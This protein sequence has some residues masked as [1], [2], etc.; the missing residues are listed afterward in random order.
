MLPQYEAHT[1][2]P[3]P[4][5]SIYDVW[6]KLETI[7]QALKRRAKLVGQL[8]DGDDA[9]KK[10]ASKL[11]ACERYP[12]C[13][14]PICPMCVRA[15]RCWFICQAIG[16]INGLQLSNPS[17]LRGKVVRFSAVPPEAYRFGHLA[18]ADL[19]ALN[20][21]LQKRHE[22]AEFPLVFAG[23][24]ISLNVFDNSTS[25]AC[26]QPHVYGLIIGLTPDQVRV[27]L[28]GH[29]PP[30]K[31][32]RR[33]LLVTRCKKLAA[34]LSY[35]IKPYFSRRSGY[36][37]DHNGRR[38]NRAQPLNGSQ[39]QELAAWLDHYRLED[40][41]LL[42]GCRKQGSSIAVNPAVRAELLGLQ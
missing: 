26:W 22:R 21:K 6:P 16:C 15:L 12:R 36:H 42:R 13:N 11:A 8:H 31:H 32:A 34:V 17:A 30:G 33:P 41:Y 39:M 24:D 27:A 38:N 29:Y 35:C 2:Y 1:N 4:N 7:D 20:N 14:S 9:A 40:R 5:V 3:S 28:S 18:D 37:D 10:L 25:D 23:V 19:W